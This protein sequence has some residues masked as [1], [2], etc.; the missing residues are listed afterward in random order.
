MGQRLIPQVPQV[1]GLSE[2]QVALVLD[3]LRK[4]LSLS[5][6]LSSWDTL[7]SYLHGTLAHSPLE[8]FHVLY[9]DR[10]NRLIHDET[11]SHGTVDH[12]PVYPREVLL[13]ALY[14]NASA[15]IIAHNHPSGDP[16]PSRSDL[17]MTKTLQRVLG[18]LDIVLHD[19]VIIG[20]DTEYSF[21][22]HGDLK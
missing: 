11:I 3:H 8:L 5:P 16:N 19:H 18:T 13:K 14:H 1:P 21:R 15:L 4:P 7:I 9:L 12:C 2:A 17:T 6:V 20:H 22:S 10:K